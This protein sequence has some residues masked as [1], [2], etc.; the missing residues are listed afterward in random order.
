MNVA[1]RLSSGTAE[2][3]FGRPAVVTSINLRTRETQEHR[4]TGRGRLEL[5]AAKY[6]LQAAAASFTSE[7]QE[8][9]VKAGDTQ[10]IT[11]VLKA[12]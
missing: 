6:S 12:G 8:I 3:A 4:I 2:T 10:E 11:F 1:I 9:A 7:A 5:P